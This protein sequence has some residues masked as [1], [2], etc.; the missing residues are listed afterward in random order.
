MS[1][2]D[3]EA[4]RAVPDWMSAVKIDLIERDGIGFHAALSV[5]NVII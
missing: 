4:P 5:K 1:A 3:A 2:K